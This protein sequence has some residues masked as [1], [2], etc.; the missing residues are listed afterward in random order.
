MAQ[1]S[2]STVRNMMMEPTSYAS[3]RPNPNHRLSVLIFLRSHNDF[4][5]KIGLS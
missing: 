4:I 2:P 5:R 3:V 1:Q